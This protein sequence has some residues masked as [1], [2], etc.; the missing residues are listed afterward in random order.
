MTPTYNY[1]F[2]NVTGGKPL[3]ETRSRE[4]ILGE[5]ERLGL[6]HIASIADSYK[7]EA[8]LRNE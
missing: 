3:H 4:F 7:T 8:E 1:Q 2:G 5:L 6:M